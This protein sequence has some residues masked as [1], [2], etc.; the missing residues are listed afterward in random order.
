MSEGNDN[1][2]L[3]REE[4]IEHRSL[5]NRSAKR[6]EVQPDTLVT[7][8]NPPLPTIEERPPTVDSADFVSGARVPLELAVTAADGG[9]GIEYAQY[10]RDVLKVQRDHKANATLSSD[11][12]PTQMLPEMMQLPLVRT[13]TGG[14]TPAQIRLRDLLGEGGMGV[15]HLAQQYPLHR[16]VAVKTVRRGSDART[17]QALLH[18][19]MITGYLEHPNVI[20]I[21]NVGRDESGEPLIVMKRVEGVTWDAVMRDP[22]N[23]P[24]SSDQVIDLDWH[25]NVLLNVCNAVRLAHDKGIIHRDIKPDNVMLGKYGE[26][27]VLDWGIAVSMGNEGSPTF[28]MTAIEWDG[29]A[30]TPAYMA[31]EMTYDNSDRVDHRSDVFLL[32]AVLHEVLTGYAP[33]GFDRVEVALMNA[34]VCGP[35]TYAN[36]VPIG[37]QE[38][39]RK[40]M[41]KAPEDRYQ[42]V[43]EFQEAL[44]DFRT[45]RQSITMAQEADRNIDKLESWLADWDEKREQEFVQQVIEARFALRQSAR[46]WEDN[47]TAESALDRLGKISFE[48]ALRAEDIGAATAALVDMKP[49]TAA[50]YRPKIDAIRSRRDEAKREL[51]E[52]RRQFD[53]GVS[54][55]SRLW[56]AIACALVWATMAS[57]KAYVRWGVPLDDVDPNYLMSIIPSAGIPFIISLFF[58]KHLRSTALNKTVQH[59]LLGGLASVAALRVAGWAGDVPAHATTSAEFIVYTFIAYSFGAAMHNRTLILCAVPLGCAAVLAIIFPMYQ[60]A[61]MAAAFY[62]F[63]PLVAFVWS[64]QISHTK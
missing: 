18:E 12:L 47:P 46:Q 64:A 45:R 60:Y 36:S 28:L 42:N 6:L 10:I 61:F 40:A 56:L 35:K 23:A 7:P 22:L 44:T 15:V 59:F 32:G 4:T 30:G 62:I 52:L 38:I 13:K 11:Q 19:A 29:I 39:A 24:T 14:A 48:H 37:L 3:S 17:I 63:A 54:G 2:D 16:E 31:P 41:A 57:Y 43:E 49:S 55:D 5:R 58:W 27:Y 33:N 1:P 9:Q 51:N 8:G 26:V 50:V 25:L 34:Y 21:H 20:P 53:F